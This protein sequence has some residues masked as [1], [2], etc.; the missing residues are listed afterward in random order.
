MSST[1][2]ARLPMLTS[3]QQIEHLKKK[4]V[5]FQLCSEKDAQ[6]YLEH[7]NN[8]FKIRSYRK[9]FPKRQ[10]GPLAGTYVGLDFAMLRDLAVIDMR[11]RY[12]FL[13]LILDVEH[14]SK[15][16]LLDELTAHQVDP[17]DIVTGFLMQ[18]PKAITDIRRNISNPYCGGIIQKYLGNMPVWVLLEV[19][20]FGMFVAF[21]KYCATRLNDMD[22]QS[23]FHV[24]IN[25]RQLRNAC[26]HS[27]CLIHNMNEKNGRGKLPNETARALS[28]GG[29]PRSRKHHI[30]NE[31]IRQITILL[32]AHSHMFKGRKLSE[33]TLAALHDL[34]SRMIRHRAWYVNNQIIPGKFSFLRDVMYCFFP[35]LRSMD[36]PKK[37]PVRCLRA[38]ALAHALQKTRHANI[39]KTP[40]SKLGH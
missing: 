3:T 7:H 39:D 38:R 5:T 18:Q 21:Y 13:H 11:M 12:T 14:F 9:N 40:E 35:G 20:S 15:V 37:P 19:L 23:D 2:A 4:G 6:S 26:A 32:Y 8:Y 31:S 34:A 28:Q 30:E 1:A 22:L 33:R 10:G 36:A 24:L 25:I 29:I 16:K 17:Y 27:N